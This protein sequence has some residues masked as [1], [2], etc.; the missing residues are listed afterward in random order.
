[1]LKGGVTLVPS[2]F[3]APTTAPTLYIDVRVRVTALLPAIANGDENNPKLTF[4][5]QTRRTISFVE[6]FNDRIG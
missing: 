5:T 1:M 4:L 2:S 3:T 6:I